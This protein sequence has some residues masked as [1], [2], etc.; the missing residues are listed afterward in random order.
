MKTKHRILSVLTILALVASLTAVM[1]APAGAQTVTASPDKGAVGTVVTV[2]GTWPVA[3]YITSVTFAGA[4][5][6][7]SPALPLEIKTAGDS[8]TITFRVPAG[9]IGGKTIA[10]S[11]GV[12]TATDTFTI[13]PKVTISPRRGPR[14]STATATVTGFAAGVAIDVFAG[15]KRVGGGITDGKGSDM[16]TLTMTAA[17][18]ITATDGA[19]NDSV[20]PV[21][22]HT[23]AFTPGI[24]LDPITGLGG[25]TV[26]IEGRDFTK[27]GNIPAHNILFAGTAVGPAVAITLTDRDADGIK[28][29]FRATITIPAGETPGPKVVRVTDD[30][31]GVGGVAT[32]TFDVIGP[33]LDAI[34][35][36]P[37]DG[38][39]G[40]SVLVTG[41]HFPELKWVSLRFADR[42]TELDDLKDPGRSIVLASAVPIDSLGNLHPTTVTIPLVTPAKYKIWAIQEDD[43]GKVSD[44]ALFEVKAPEVVTGVR[45]GLNAVWPQ[46]GE[47]VWQFKDG[48]WYQYLKAT[49]EMVPEAVRLTELRSG[50]AYWI[51]LAADITDIHFGGAK[52][53]LEAGWHNIAWQ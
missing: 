50:M 23:F 9:P 7:T 31:G 40:Q 44:D 47:S 5:V 12:R 11:D 3:G 15:G 8:Y 36:D 21:P 18:A 33:A 2:T 51:Y 29:D 42:L 17:G 37:E 26:T 34:T 35:L 48:V 41:V 28:D 22:P 43:L 27:D 20:H 25:I 38:V 14:G 1:V 13:E 49:P 32:A 4:A 10:V 24:T 52:R 39:P 46:L 53:T 30:V 45:D 16:V 19:G 6:T